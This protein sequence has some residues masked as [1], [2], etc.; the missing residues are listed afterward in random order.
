MSDIFR[1][2]DEEV[3]H[4]RYT[5]LWK[6]F[7]PYVIAI[8]VIV[9]IFVAGWRTWEWYQARR[10]AELGQAYFSALQLARNG[11]HE[12]A[13]EAFGELATT[14]DAYGTL[15]ALRQA[16]ELAASGD[17]EGAVAAYDEISDDASVSQLLRGLARVRAGYLLVDSADP[18]ALLERMQGYI[19]DPES[20]WRNAAREIQGLAAYR[21]GEYDAASAYFEEILADPEAPQDLLQRA[22]MMFTLLAAGS[23]DQL[24]PAELP[25]TPATSGTADQ[26]VPAASEADGTNE[27]TQ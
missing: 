1:E 27:A 14:G 20:P 11:Q 16:A 5:A 7:G 12:Q 10:A 4:E 26:E 18:E 6:R 23:S 2:V 22:Q 17:T 13:S 25:E 21:A 3:R 19:D 15:A 9:V 8:A 24:P